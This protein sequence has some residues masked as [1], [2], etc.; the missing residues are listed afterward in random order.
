MAI[1][2]FADTQGRISF[3]QVASG[4]GSVAVGLARM[5][6]QLTNAVRFTAGGVSIPGPTVVAWDFD[7][8]HPVN[9]AAEIRGVRLLGMPWR[10]GTPGETFLYR[11]ADPD[12][13]SPPEGRVTRIEIDPTAAP[14]R[15]ATVSGTQTLAPG[16]APSLW[17]VRGHL[18]TLGMNRL[19][20][21]EGPLAGINLDANLPGARVTLNGKD[22]LLG[23]LI[24][25]EIAWQQ[26]PVR[27]TLT[28]HHLPELRAE[29]LPQ[30]PEADIK[31]RAL[32]LLERKR[33]APHL[34]A[35]LASRETV[36]LHWRYPA[37]A[38]PTELAGFNVYRATGDAPTVFTRINEEPIP[39]ATATAP[40]AVPPAVWPPASSTPGAGSLCWFE[41]PLL[42]GV[43]TQYFYR[44]TAVDD[45][46]LESAPNPQAG[47]QVV[48][49]DRAGPPS[50]VFVSVRRQYASG[51]PSVLQG[52]RIE[53]VKPQHAYDVVL[54]RKEAGS[55]AAA[56]EIHRAG[57][58]DLAWYLDAGP[59]LPAT[60]YEYVL[61]G[62]SGTLGTPSV[63]RTIAIGTSD[64]PPSVSTPLTAT[65][66]PGSVLLAWGPPTLAP[67]VSVTGYVVERRKAG[68]AAFR[69][70]AGPLT[71][72]TFLDDR[73]VP[74]TTY[75]YRIVMVDSNDV[76][77]LSLF[78][79]ASATVP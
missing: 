21:P 64:V 41:D 25:V 12:R 44:V 69:L 32:S 59:F 51:S 73:V 45:T 78:P 38:T 10:L 33:Y 28:F 5:H 11:W 7:S 26:G 3:P 37:P 27:I 57:P 17:S 42:G 68:T 4:T 13:R 9:G 36:V 54:F 22:Y 67:G 34:Q 46:G 76:M 14:G 30:W 49:P 70:R 47:L 8:A 56:V 24:R 35:V 40:I 61:R 29:H 50:P 2:S 48:V 43:G 55:S 39:F 74:G 71:A 23:D 66:A 75:E 62:D 72:T 6:V 18:V 15:K 77:W 52:V 31:A 16:A 53:W 65:A 19:G 1:P 20:A 79:V 63:T 58:A 60:G